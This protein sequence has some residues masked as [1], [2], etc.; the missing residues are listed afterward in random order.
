MLFTL[1]S[2]L[3]ISWSHKYVDKLFPTS[4]KI[5]RLFFLELSI[6][7]GHIMFVTICKL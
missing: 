3:Q 2:D 6:Y 5:K 7:S 4:K 1:I